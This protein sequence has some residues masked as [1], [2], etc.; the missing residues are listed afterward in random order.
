MHDRVQFRH[1]VS[2]SVDRVL[3]CCVFSQRAETAP[4]QPLHATA[5]DC[6]ADWAVSLLIFARDKMCMTA[7]IKLDYVGAVTADR[8]LVTRAHIVKVEGRKTFIAFEGVSLRPYQVHFTGSAIMIEV[9]ASAVRKLSTSPGQMVHGIGAIENEQ[10]AADP[11]ARV[12]LS[13]VA[14]FAAPETAADIALFTSVMAPQPLRPRAFEFSGEL[15][16]MELRQMP[17]AG[18]LGS[19]PALRS[20]CYFSPRSVGPGSVFGGCGAFHRYRRCVC[21]CVC[22]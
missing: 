2:P 6:A 9:P 19:E 7:E 16:S 5:V 10:E 4:N 12:Q 14:D 22:G 1:Y 17:R 21:V 13:P 15:R 8:L 18:P 11:D 20:V 3:T